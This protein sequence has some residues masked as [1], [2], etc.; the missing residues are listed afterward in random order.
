MAGLLTALSGDWL[1]AVAV[2][3]AETGRLLRLTRYLGGR[4]VRVTELRSVGPVGADGFGFTPPEGVPVVEKPVFA[5][6]SDDSDSP[7]EWETHGVHEINL[8][9]PIADEF[10]RQAGEAAR[11]IFGPFRGGSR[12]DLQ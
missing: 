1:P 5:P 9:A 3:D 6:H 8:L 7:G 12:A 11:R 4:V 10:K 2:V